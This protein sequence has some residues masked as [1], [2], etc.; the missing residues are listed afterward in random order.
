M[1]ITQYSPEQRRLLSASTAASIVSRVDQRLLE[2]LNQAW[3][4]PSGS[5]ERKFSKTTPCKVGGLGGISDENQPSDWIRCEFK[6]ISRG[7]RLKYR[8][9]DARSLGDAQ[10]AR[11]PTKQPNNEKAVC[12]VTAAER[13]AIGKHIARLKAKSSVRLKVSKN[14]SDPQISLDHPDELIGRALLMEA[15]ASADD[16][17]VNGIVSQLAN[18]GGRGQDINERGLNFMLSVIKGTE[19]RNQLEAMLA[20]QMAA[21]HMASMTFA[22]RLAHVDDIG[23]RFQ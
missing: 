2:R 1:F 17:F 6:P 10:M 5:A 14:G 16:D 21:V 23:T 20:A 13:S 3:G 11:R 8:F 4:L 7:T 12:K 9:C 18:V 22:G 19:A 15:L